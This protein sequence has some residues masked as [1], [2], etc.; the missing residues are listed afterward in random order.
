[1]QLVVNSGPQ[2]VVIAPQ[3]VAEEVAQNVRM[4]VATPKGSVPLDRDFGLDFNLIDQPMPR[5][6]ALMDAE[7]VRQ[8][9]KYEPR[10]SVLSI[11]WEENE[12][13]AMDGR[14]NPIV[15]IEVTEAA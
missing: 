2:P 11:R 3:T 7:I 5:A 9:A 10:A 6:K 4:I 8:V 14:A 1:M 13:E 15:T 12:D